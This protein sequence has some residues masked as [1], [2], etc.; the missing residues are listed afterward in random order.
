MMMMIYKINYNQLASR[1]G[2]L[3]LCL[4]WMQNQ[5]D[6]QKSQR[7]GKEW[8]SSKAKKKIRDS[9]MMSVLEFCGYLMVMVGPWIKPCSG[10]RTCFEFLVE[11]P[12]PTPS[13]QNT[14]KLTKSIRIPT[15]PIQN[16]PR[17]KKIKPKSTQAFSAPPPQNIRKILQEISQHITEEQVEEIEKSEAQDHQDEDDGNSGLI[18]GFPGNPRRPCFLHSRNLMMQTANSHVILIFH[19]DKKKMIIFNYE[20]YLSYFFFSFLCSLQFYFSLMFNSLGIISIIRSLTFLIIFLI[21]WFPFI[22][23]HQIS[24]RISGVSHPSSVCKIEKPDRSRL[25][26]SQDPLSNANNRSTIV[27]YSSI[28]EHNLRKKK[29]QKQI[30]KITGGDEGVREELEMG[31]VVKGS[32]SIILFHTRGIQRGPEQHSGHSG[33]RQ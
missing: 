18:F 20:W 8:M 28:K 17:I 19:L 32:N 22:L 7:E 14:P 30:F 2:I 23:A 26:D 29:S 6:S 33:P 11:A 12:I 10:L 3:K 31:Q 1:N 21:I 27:K 25:E 16:L 5:R 9:L 24:Q 15:K 4:L 13:L